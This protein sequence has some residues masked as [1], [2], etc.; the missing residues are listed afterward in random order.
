MRDVVGQTICDHGD[1][2]TVDQRETLTM[3]KIPI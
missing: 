3:R 1:T 2:L